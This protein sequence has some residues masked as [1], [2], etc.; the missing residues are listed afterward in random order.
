VHTRPTDVIKFVGNLPATLTQQR[1]IA[2]SFEEDVFGPYMVA[3]AQHGR[4]RLAT[5]LTRPETLT[6][7]LDVMAG[8]YQ[9]AAEDYGPVF[10][11]LSS[12][13]LW[14]H[15][16]NVLHGR[17]VPLP[18]RAWVTA[19]QGGCQAERA[20]RA[21]AGVGPLV[22]MEIVALNYGAVFT[23]DTMANASL[24]LHRNDIREL[25]TTSSV[26]AMPHLT[27]AN[28]GIGQS[29]ATFVNNAMSMGRKARIIEIGSG[30]GG[31]L[32]A[33]IDS[34][35]QDAPTIGPSN[36]S[37]IALEATPEF[38]EQLTTFAKSDDGARRL[39][40][41]VACANAQG[42]EIGRAG[43]LTAVYGDALEAIRNA[44]WVNDDD[45]INV[46]TAN[47]SLHRMPMNAKREMFGLL[48]RLPHVA[49][50]IGDLWDN[51]SELNRKYFDLAVNGPLNPGNVG[52]MEVLRSNAFHVIDSSHQIPAGVN[53][54]LSRRLDAPER[55]AH[56][57]VGASSSLAL[58]ALDLVTISHNVAPPF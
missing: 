20:N 22:R 48:R 19:E 24:T 4:R 41:S 45:A 3:M 26:E 55:D 17:I 33:V 11:K 1:R 21:L 13:Q 36:L 7:A 47:Y 28:Y 51:S 25:T 49:L 18:E 35:C 23:N 44:I 29:V 46:V 39:N 16:Q 6:G 9:Q 42:A 30:P 53:P 34:I 52:L 40:L 38:Y 27:V 43:T 57:T 54:I 14:E 2:S 12:A 58:S 5:K 31:T 8:L 37:I 32:A 10:L 50:L 15:Q 56:F